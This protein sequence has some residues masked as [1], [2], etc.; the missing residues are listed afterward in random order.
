M[1]DYV[2]IGAFQSVVDS[3]KQSISKLE[4]ELSSTKSSLQTVNSELARIKADGTQTSDE[5]KDIEQLN[6]Q[7]TRADGPDSKEGKGEADN[8]VQNSGYMDVLAR[9]ASMENQIKE[10][11]SLQ[12]LAAVDDSIQDIEVRVSSLENLVNPIINDSG[13]DES[14]IL[15]EELELESLI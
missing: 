12:S 15:T 6:L 2:T 5:V 7:N 10:M 9:V 11:P 4:G 1:P 14:F 3:L 13:I 8:P